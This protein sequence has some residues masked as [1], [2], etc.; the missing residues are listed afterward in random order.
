M[1]RGA[2]RGDS[3]GRGQ[4]SQYNGVLVC[5][6]PG[7]AGERTTAVWLCRGRAAARR[8]SLDRVSRVRAFM[9]H[10]VTAAATSLSASQSA[11]QS[12]ANVIISSHHTQRPTVPATH[13]SNQTPL[14]DEPRIIIKHG[15]AEAAATTAT[16]IDQSN[17]RP[18]IK[19]LA[20]Y[21]NNRRLEGRDPGRQRQIGVVRQRT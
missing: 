13:A 14:S 4:A 15:I 9:R 17:C 16:S 3:S 2:C 20:S 12:P 18:V 7:T 10:S 6:S 11:S 1:Q 21:E 19:L 5:R 8:C